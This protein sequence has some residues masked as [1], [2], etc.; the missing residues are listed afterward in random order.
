ALIHLEAAVALARR[1]DLAEQE[2]SALVNASDLFMVSDLPE[3]ARMAEDAV[4]A[5]RRRGDPYS[6]TIAAS[7]LLY[8]WLY[9]GEWG[10]VE[11]L[12]ADLL[13]PDG[14]GRVNAEL[15][16]LRAAV[17]AGWRGDAAAAQTEVD[18]LVG[19]RT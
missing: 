15:L 2:L 3:A 13:G 8:V 18:R 19:L 14:Q 4:A 5:S 9:A 11:Q 1:H 16:I 6:E 12:L 10:R 17:L 7:N